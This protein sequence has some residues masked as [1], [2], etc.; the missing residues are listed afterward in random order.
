MKGHDIVIKVNEFVS[1][2][3]RQPAEIDLQDYL[4]FVNRVRKR[5][6]ELKKTEVM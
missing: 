4:L 3:I 1:M 5:L 6:E 2:K